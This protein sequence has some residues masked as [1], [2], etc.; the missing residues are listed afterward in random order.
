[1]PIHKEPICGNFAG[2][3]VTIPKGWLSLDLIVDSSSESNI[4]V[5]YTNNNSYIL[6]AGQARTIQF[7]GSGGGCETVLTVPAGTVGSYQACY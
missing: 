4:T 2:T 1:M 7:D 3:N 6:M 5:T